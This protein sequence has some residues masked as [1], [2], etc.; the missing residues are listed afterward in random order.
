MLLFFVVSPSDVPGAPVIVVSGLA[1][2]HLLSPS[3]APLPPPTVTSAVTGELL[4]TPP[5]PLPPPNRF[6][7]RN[8]L[9]AAFSK[10]LLALP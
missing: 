3:A 5:T 9:R 10:S 7:P 4:R 1:L 6:L 8:I 2:L